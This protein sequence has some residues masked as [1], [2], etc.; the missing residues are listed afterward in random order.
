MDTSRKHVAIDSARGGLRPNACFPRT[1][2]VLLWTLISGCTDVDLDVILPYRNDKLSVEGDLC[3]TSP[4]K[5]VYTTRILFL[6]DCSDSMRW[7]DPD[8]KRADAIREMV[9]KY[10][11]EEAVL[12]GI[13]RFGTTVEVETPI[14]TKDSTELFAALDPIQD[15]LDPKQFLGGTDYVAVLRAASDFI[16]KDQVTN[17]QIQDAAYITVFIADGAPQASDFDPAVTVTKIFDQVRTLHSMG[18]ILDTIMLSKEAMGVPPEFIDVLPDMAAEGGGQYRELSG[19]QTISAVLGDILDLSKLLRVFDLRQFVAYNM[20]ALAYETNGKITIEPDSDGDGLADVREL[21]LRTSPIN[22]D[23]DGDLIGDLVEIEVGSDPTATERHGLPPEEFVDDD[24]DGLNNYEEKLLGTRPD[25]FDSDRDGLPDGLELRARANPMLA[26]ERGD[27]DE[28][29]VPNVDEIRGHTLTR[30]D[31]KTVRE[32]ISYRYEVFKTGRNVGTYC[33]HFQVDNITLRTT[34][35]HKDFPEGMN[36]IQILA[37]DSPEDHPGLV[38][39][40][41]Q[42][43]LKIIFREPNYRDPSALLLLVGQEDFQ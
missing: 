4:G 31:D 21:E 23:T 35:P 15:P 20:N 19:A 13:L 42:T 22:G 24:H 10:Q 43:T 2:F 8:G 26:D 1:C 16:L 18:A 14:F 40:L 37:V 25:A 41:F 33:Y 27:Y 11:N 6:I 30:I 28:D 5:I 9:T 39:H 29:I 12:F 17:T 36:R 3:T 38:G 34:L 32:S 7:N